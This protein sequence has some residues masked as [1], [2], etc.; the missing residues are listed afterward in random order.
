EAGAPGPQGLEPVQVPLALLAVAQPEDVIVGGAAAVLEA[1]GEGVQPRQV[2]A[3][4]GAGPG[5]GDP[6]LA[7]RVLPR[8]PQ[9]RGGR[10]AAAA[11]CDK[12]RQRRRAA[13]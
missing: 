10:A 7:A 2:A 9:V 8:G 5:A 3:V 6:E 13:S 11:R 1:R 4:R 12:E